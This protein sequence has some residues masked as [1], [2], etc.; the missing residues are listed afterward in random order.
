MTME[1]HVQATVTYPNGMVMH[2][3]ARMDECVDTLGKART[4][5][6]GTGKKEGFGTWIDNSKGQSYVLQGNSGDRFELIDVEEWVT[7]SRRLRSR[8]RTR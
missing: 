3:S 4:Y 8:E 7:G 2:D 1:S 5:R 6:N